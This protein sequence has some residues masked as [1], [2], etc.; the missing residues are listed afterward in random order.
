MRHASERP[1]ELRGPNAQVKEE[2]HR[3]A[4]TTLLTGGAGQ[5]L[6]L[7]VQVHLH[8]DP[9]P[10]GSMLSREASLGSY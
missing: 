7:D 6:D 10:L 5:T 9:E 3:L 2:R 8:C 4:G 1:A